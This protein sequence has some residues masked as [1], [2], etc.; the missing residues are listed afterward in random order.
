MAS[1]AMSAPKHEADI[2]VSTIDNVSKPYYAIS[3]GCAVVVL[4]DKIRVESLFNDGSELNLI[5]EVVHRELEHPID[6]NIHWR[7]NGVDSTIEEE[8]DE[9][10]G[11]DHGNVLGVLHNVIV[12]GGGIK[13]KQHIFVV[14]YLQMKLILGHPWRRSAYAVFANEDD[15]SDTV[16]I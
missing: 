3:A 8:L 4:D 1:A 12:D 14:G 16:T 2:Q 9:R 13:V 5:V 6:G 7:I 11:V 10:Y 15:G